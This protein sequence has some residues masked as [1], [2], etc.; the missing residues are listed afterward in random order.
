MDSPVNDDED[1]YG[2]LYSNPEDGEEIEEEEEKFSYFKLLD[3]PRILPEPVDL[4]HEHLKEI[5]YELG[6]IKMCWPEVLEPFFEDRTNFP[7]R[8][9]KN[10]EK[11]KVLLLYTEN[12]RKQFV[13]KFP[14]RK[15]LLLAAENEC[16][17]VKMVCTTIR[18]TN[19]PY[20]E[21][22]TWQGCA[23]FLADHIKFE[24]MEDIPTLLPIRLYSPHTTLLRQSGQTFELATTLCSIL[25]GVGYDAFVVSGYAIKDVTLRIMIRTD[26]PIPPFK[27]EE[28]KPPETP[29][30]E[31]Y[32][33]KPPKDLRSKFLLMMEQRELDKVR[34]KEA[35]IAEEARKRLEEEARPEDELEGQRIHAWVLILPSEKD[36]QEP[37]Y[38]EPSTGFSHPLDTDIYLGI[39]SIW[40]HQN[41]YV[42]LQDC[43][44]GM[45]DLEFD[46]QNNEKWI[47]FL[48][49]EPMK[50]RKQ[51]PKD[52]GD[53]DDVRDMYEEKHL[54]MPTSWSMKINIPHESLKKRFPEGYRITNYKRVLIEEYAPFISYDGLVTRITRFQDFDCTIP[55]VIEEEFENRHDK[56]YRS[57]QM[58]D[59]NLVTDYFRKGREDA[60]IKHVYIRN[61]DEVNAARTI[62]FNH[63]GRYDALHKI[64]VEPNK[65]TE[66]YKDRDDRLYYRQVTYDTGEDPVA[67]SGPSYR[68]PILK[69]IQ[70]Y[71]RDESKPSHEDI[72]SREF[73]IVGREIRIKFH[74][75]KNNVT[76]STRVFMKPPLSDIGEEMVFDPD[77]TYGYQ[78]EIGV[79]RPRQLTLYLMFEEQLKEEEK[80]INNI[81]EVE[82]QISEFLLIRA[83]EMAFSKLDVPLFNIEQNAEYRQ[84]MLDKEEQARVYKE[85]E[86]EEDVDYFAPYL[87]KLGGPP[88]LTFSQ[89]KEARDCC[90]REF[91]ELL[92]NRANV[93][94]KQFEKMSDKLQAKKLYYTATHDVLTPQ[95]EADYFAE[96]NNIMLVMKALQ[97]RLNRHKELASVRY[98]VMANYLFHHPMLK[99]LYRRRKK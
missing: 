28:E 85:K 5:G 62:F 76:A 41:Y 37:F 40:N 94:Q 22:E 82:A 65:I 49:A 74:Y 45:A 4:T 86:I 12:F 15:P 87:A 50:Y 58:C 11:E 1:V 71:E 56:F 57:I 73:A 29:I 13:Q 90:L 32:K 70:K 30:E 67:K 52:L 59:T 43:S 63:E 51:K 95:E 80:V 39:E 48:V 54:D 8:Y 26:C 96:V 91:K 53:D 10:N 61:N 23:S 77:M 84:A 21:L 2:Y 75:G 25:I 38:I 89:A 33:L 20:P 55:E 27:E 16:G 93:M 60:V 81:R 44:K 31:K 3:K 18:P 7:M 97:I 83:R 68:R 69:V 88:R 47:H 42:N 17:I 24:P 98:Q 66:H 46:L 9:L 78:A 92:V 35:K 79:K 6:L 34:E 72:A 99:V 36:V 19:V 14:D 64:E